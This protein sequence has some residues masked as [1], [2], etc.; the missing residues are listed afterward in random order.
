M[1]QS[2]LLRRTMVLVLGA[3]TMAM[4]MSSLAFLM[5][6]R[7][8]TM[9]MDIQSALQQES[10]YSRIFEMDPEFLDDD[11]YRSYFF[12]VTANAGRDYYLFAEDKTIL[13]STGNDLINLSSANTDLAIN[14]FKDSNLENFS[15]GLNYQ[16]I[17]S[18]HWNSKILII[19]QKVKYNS[20]DVYLV[21]FSVIDVYN[22]VVM[23]FL[24]ILLLS[25]MLAA[26]AMLVPTYIL[27]RKI[28]LP[29]Q[30]INDVATEY[31]RGNLSVRADE[32]HKGE[33]GE[34][35]TSFNNLA[36]KLSKS[37]N[38]LTTEKNRLQDIFD[39]ISDGI[40]VVDKDANPIITNKDFAYAV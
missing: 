26:M 1:F 27:V 23:E 6:G 30:Q 37:I 2:T 29:I 39:V 19:V 17:D 3:L 24:N 4:L 32:S 35:G 28:V 9:D 8:T 22:D 20:T 16:T 38:D 12:S 21:S 33:V 14:Y 5:A 25:T 40:V 13:M 31:A 36:D 15:E 11:N 7:M 10:V 18:D 34:L